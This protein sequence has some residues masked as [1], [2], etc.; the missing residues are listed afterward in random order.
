MKPTA[1]R[2]FLILIIISMLSSVHSSQSTGSESP[3]SVEKAVDFLVNTQFNKS[4]GLC[5]E[6]PMVANNCYWLVSDNLWAWKALKVA[7]ETY[8]FGGGGVGRAAGQIERSLKEKRRVYS[9]PN[10]SNGFPASFMHE[11][12]IGDAIPT[13][14]RMSS[15]LKL[16]SDGYFVRTEVV[17]GTPMPDWRGYADRLLYMALSCFWRGEKANASHYLSKCNQHVGRRRHKR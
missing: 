12:V 4:L 6:A 14:N 7:D 15:N 8:Y 3:T 1:S 17:N 11:A 13:P 9:L 5:S 2:M 10:D 16:Y